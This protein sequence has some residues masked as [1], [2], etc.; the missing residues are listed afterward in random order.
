MRIR[1]LALVALSIVVCVSTSVRAQVLWSSPGGSEWLQ[2]ANWTGGQVPSATNIAQFDANPTPGTSVGINFNEPTNGGVV[3]GGLSIQ[4]VGA[5]EVTSARTLGLT[6]GNSATAANTNGEFRFNS[7]TVNGVANTILRNASSQTLTIQNTQGAGTR[8]MAVGLINP[9]NVITADGAGSIAILSNL[10]EVGGTRSISVNTNGTG[11]V[12]L[13]GVNTFNGGITVNGTASGGRLRLDATTALSTTGTINVNTGGRLAFN[14][15]GSF[16][17]TTQALVLNPNQS[18]VA[19]LESFG[20]LAATWQGTVAVNAASRV[21]VGTG[22]SL[23]LARTVSGSG[24]LIK[25]GAGNL[26]LAGTANTRTGDTQIAG[27]T[28]TVN[29][30]STLGGGALT[31]AQEGT[32]NTAVV[33]NNASQAIGNLSSQFSASSGTI[34]QTITLNGTALTVNQT[35]D[36]TF[37]N[38]AV[39]TLTSVLAGTGSLTKTG[40]AVLT[41]GGPSTYTGA[42]TVNAG[43]L[44]AGIES[45]A[46]TSGAFGRNSNVTLANNAGVTLDLNGFN[47]QIGTLNGGGTTAVGVTLGS[48]TLTVGGGTA[49]AS[50]ATYAGA[51]TGTGGLTKTGAGTQA[52]TGTN[53]YSG[54][55][56]VNQGTLLFTNT[57]ALYNGNDANWTDTNIVVNSGGVLALRLGD[58]TNGFTAGQ[59]LSI[60]QL[61]TATGG[62]RDGSLLGIDTTN[63]DATFTNAFTNTNSGANGIGLVKLGANTLTLTGNNTYSGPTVIAAGTLQVGGGGNSGSLGTGAVTNNG[64]LV[65]NRA[66]N[67]EVGNPISGT[68]GL[69]F[70]GTG[71]VTLTGTNSYTGTTNVNAG[72]L[73]VNGNN[74]ASTGAITVA[75]GSTLGG[76]GTLGGATNVQNGG[77]I[78]ADSGTS[79]GALAVRNVTVQSGGT[80]AVN[81]GAMD[82]NLNG[83]SNRL[84]FAS[85]ILDLK[86]G[87]VVK[88]TAAT[89]FGAWSSGEFV[90]GTF[91][92]GN[93][94]L[95]D[96]VAT[97]NGQVLGEYIYGAGTPNSGPIQIDV[98]GLPTLLDDS[99]LT[100]MRN[101]NNLVLSF[102]PVPEPASLLAVC[103]LV[104]GGVVAVRKLRR[105]ATPTDVTS[106]V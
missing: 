104:I 86:T 20:G 85:N 35:V 95:L 70:N 89:G 102:S 79:T 22:G 16:G 25:Q 97:T 58:G 47:T 49:A 39:S 8:T 80:L 98:T 67:A 5:I 38:G 13:G 14:A 60:S 106:A 96:A 2:G 78:Q 87:A 65:F 93:N 61:G 81:L 90:L 66:D 94:I 36:G 46:N 103:G 17:G 30:G 26:I 84:A 28:L 76:T 44:R 48:G 57:S 9:T 43:T 45:V 83:T 62:F 99:K 37:G 19:A 12:R 55:T 74:S 34:N 4:L 73:L 53:D 71:T 7:A 63:G 24:L 31:L 15:A 41:L 29:S 50:S 10:I 42:T 68:G 18:T 23:T 82:E 6:I 72:T 91:S 27:G 100:L 52:L 101:G 69:V 32:S 54:V 105:K 56:T 11:D 21:E 3:I 92:N 1:P 40:A 33:F 88:F 64:V 51:I 75:S 77:T 59:L